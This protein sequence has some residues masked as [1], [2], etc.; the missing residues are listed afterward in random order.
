MLL[1]LFFLSLGRPVTVV[2]R[3]RNI[4]YALISH[5]AVPDDFV[6]QLFYATEGMYYR[7]LGL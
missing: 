5:V 6:G 3:M 7:E 2:D 1:I 4:I